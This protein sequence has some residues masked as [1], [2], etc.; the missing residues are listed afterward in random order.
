MSH[1]LC[2]VQILKWGGVGS[3][4]GMLSVTAAG[5]HTQGQHPGI[6]TDVWTALYVCM[7]DVCMYV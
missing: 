1:G 3:E 2:C 4:E 7:Y 6:T 5:V